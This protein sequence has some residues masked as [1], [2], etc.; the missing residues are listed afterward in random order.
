M[1]I[2]IR[3]ARPEDADFW[4]SLDGHLSRVAF[5]D[6]VRDRMAYVLLCDGQP[7]GLL[8]Y[9]LFW[10]EHP[11]CTMLYIAPDRQRQGL[12]ARL[13]RHWEKDMR[14]RGY[15]LALTSTQADEDA[16]RFYRRMGYRDCGGLVLD[17]PPWTQPMELIL[18]R[19]IREED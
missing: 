18:C 11:F 12:G 7:A 1:D 16:Q 5:K 14:A 19:D 9:N 13:L 8:R 2:R 15:G 6:K 10:D 3:Y 4:F 17:V